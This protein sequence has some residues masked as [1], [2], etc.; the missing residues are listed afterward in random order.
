MRWYARLYVGDG[1]A[2]RRNAILQGIRGQKIMP[3]VYVITRAIDSDGMLDIYR[4]SA[5]RQERI[6]RRDPLI[7]GVALGRRE[8]FEVAARIVTD[9]YREGGGFDIDAFC[10]AARS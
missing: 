9:V 2:E 7:L 5:F 1:A 8:A 4:Q 3:A 10:A 6:Q